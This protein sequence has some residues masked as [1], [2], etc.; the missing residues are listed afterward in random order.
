MK[1]FLKSC[2]SE[3]DGTVSFSRCITLPIVCAVLAWDSCFLKITH[4]L[5]DPMTLGAQGVLMTLF[6]GVNRSADVF[7]K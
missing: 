6:Y 2:F 1:T 4:T 7:K 5:P 3:A